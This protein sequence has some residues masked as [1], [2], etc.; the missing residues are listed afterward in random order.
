MRNTVTT[1]ATGSQAIIFN[2]PKGGW[3][4]API[5]PRDPANSNLKNFLEGAKC[6]VTFSV[7]PNSAIFRKGG[8]H[9]ITIVD[10]TNSKSKTIDT[11]H[12]VYANIPG[13]VEWT[14]TATQIKVTV[15]NHFGVKIILR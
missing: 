11:T 3:E 4:S 9:E 10:W 7:D 14:V 12:L 15:T 6:D 8:T 5:R 13:R 1:Y 2:I